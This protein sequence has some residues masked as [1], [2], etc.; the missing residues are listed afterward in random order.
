[1]PVIHLRISKSPSL[2]EDLDSRIL[3]GY[4][5]VIKPNDMHPPPVLGLKPI[6]RSIIAYK[7]DSS[8]HGSPG[9]RAEDGSILS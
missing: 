4:C 3:K 6:T 8:D 5:G 7:E 2:S 1:M 9:H